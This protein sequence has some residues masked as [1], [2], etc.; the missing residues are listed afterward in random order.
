MS[1]ADYR[2]LVASL[3]PDASNVI[4]A[5]DRERAIN[6][7]LARYSAD[8]PRELV[9][10]VTWTTQGR[11]GP[12]PQQ[13]VGGSDLVTAEF[14]IGESPRST[15]TLAV[16]RTPTAWTLLCD[17]ALDA[18]AVVRVTY[19]A[20]HLLAD[21][22]QDL[23]DAVADWLEYYFV[24]VSLPVDTIP[25]C[26]REAVA[27]YAAH[28]LCKQ[29]AAHYSADRETSINADGSNTDSRARNFAARARD[30]RAAYYAGIGKVD[31]QAPG[32]QQAR[33]SMAIGPAASASAWPG[34]VRSR[35]SLGESA[36]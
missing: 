36:L 22:D 17:Q 24:P 27:S 26:H 35:P 14:P 34:R 7:G 33:Q 20:P 4:G 1:R 32:E 12:L 13:W 31:P 11:V 3:A 15:V 18:G 9:E 28:V 6:I 21:V 10:D 16:Y 30:Y 2:L 25:V 8:V 29:L 19:R 23:T 5:E